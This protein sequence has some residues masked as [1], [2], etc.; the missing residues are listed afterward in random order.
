MNGSPSPYVYHA[1]TVVLNKGRSKPAPL[2]QSLVVIGV[3]YD[4]HVDNLVGGG[5]VC[6]D[7]Q[8]SFFAQSN[9]PELAG[10]ELTT[11]AALSVT[12]RTLRK[13]RSQS[14][15]IAVCPSPD[16]LNFIRRWQ[17]G[18]RTLPIGY[19]PY[20][21]RSRTKPSL[22]EL[23]NKFTK[24]PNW[25]LPQ[26]ADARTQDLQAAAN[27]AAQ[28][29]LDVQRGQTSKASAIVAVRKQVE[30]ALRN[31]ARSLEIPHTPT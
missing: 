28:L 9:D 10:Y 7:L 23:A 19:L 18:D 20:A 1:G 17:Q 14:G 5:F 30:S 25:F 29:A 12:W 16:A 21:R 2:T 8:Y 22:V 26:L 11:V 4:P 24:Q 27:T 31:Y 3:A 6:T 13:L 15:S